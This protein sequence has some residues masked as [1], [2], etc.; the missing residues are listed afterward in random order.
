MSYENIDINAPI[1]FNGFETFMNTQKKIKMPSKIKNLTTTQKKELFENIFYLNTAEYTY[2][3]KH[4]GIPFHIFI[5]L[6]T[7]K[8]KKTTDKD[9]KGIILKRLKKFLQ[10]GILPKPTIIK[11][12]IILLE[13]N[14]FKGINSGQKLFYGQ[15]DKYNPRMMNLLKS[16]TN[17][18][19]KD[20]SIAR[21]VLRDFW[22]NGQAPT[23]KAYAVAWLKAVATDKKV[24][25]EW[26]FLTDRSKGVNPKNWKAL[27]NKKAARVKQLLAID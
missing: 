21:E 5:E 11:K 17:G 8:L 4:Y 19:Y 25:P 2:L 24:H 23:F 9:R 22:T 10:D 15:Y 3:C 12:E 20:G 13:D 26:A 1:G 18:A 16:L 6:P 27:R 14:D 7:G